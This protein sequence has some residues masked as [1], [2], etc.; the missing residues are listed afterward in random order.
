LTGPN[1]QQA[2]GAFD[3][4]ANDVERIGSGQQG[5]QPGQNGQP[6]ASGQP[7]QNGGQGANGGSGSGSGAS[8]Q[9]PNSQ[10]GQSPTLGESSPLLG[11]DGKPIELPKGSQNGPQ[12]NTQ[13]PNGNG[14]GQTDPGAA[15][16]SGGQLRQGTVGESGV[17]PNQVPYDQRG[18]V[19]RYFTPPADEQR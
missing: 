10:Q 17:D 16:T 13:N 3:Q 1:P 12:I 18:P 19:E 2:Q 7:G 15:G 5:Q 4:V 9:L 14:N 8:P 11:A 6:G